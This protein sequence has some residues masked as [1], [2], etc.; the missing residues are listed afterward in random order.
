MKLNEQDWRVERITIGDQTMRVTHVPTRAVGHGRDELEAW[1]HL[2]SVL[3]QRLG[4]APRVKERPD[5]DVLAKRHAFA[6]AGHPAP[7]AMGRHSAELADF[8]RD[9]W[10]TR[11]AVDMSAIELAL[12]SQM[13]ATASGPYLK[14]LNRT[15]RA[16]DE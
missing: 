8:L 2:A 1:Q 5:F 11:G 6:I 7:A 15:L 12:A 4:P 14:N 9:I 16:L 3:A 10:N 13:G